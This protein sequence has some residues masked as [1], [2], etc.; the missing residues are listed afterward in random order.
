MTAF[1]FVFSLISVITSLALTRLLN[2][3]IELYRHHGPVRWSWRHGCWTTSAF[4]LLIGNWAS[5]WS[6]FHNATTW[7]APDVLLQLTFL[8][9]LYAY[10]DLVMPDKPNAHE[11]LDLQDFHERF[12]RRYK[13]VQW[14]FA[15]LAMLMLAHVAKGFGPWLNSARFALIATLVVGVALRARSVWLDTT[16]AIGQ[17]VLTTV[18]MVVRLQALSS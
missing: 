7:S 5:F 8:S 3:C 12:G 13:F 16:T 2:G 9:V 11:T 18:Y 10:C 6:R 1:E 17:A 15:L 4:T 14:L